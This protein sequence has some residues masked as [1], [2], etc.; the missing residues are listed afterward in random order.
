MG[1][2]S[3]RRPLMM[4]GQT[5]PLTPNTHTRSLRRRDTTRSLGSEV[6][7]PK[8]VSPFLFLSVA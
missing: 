7:G 4:L 6:E 5:K 3:S 2:E 8:D 1:N